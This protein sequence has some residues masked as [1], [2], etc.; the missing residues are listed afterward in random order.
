MTCPGDVPAAHPATQGPAG[1][2]G[3][4]AEGRYRHPDTSNF[5]DKATSD[6]RFLGLH[7]TA[8]DSASLGGAPAASYVS[9]THG[10]TLFQDVRTVPNNALQFVPL[11]GRPLWALHLVCTSLPTGG[12]IVSDIGLRNI[13]GEALDLFVRPNNGASFHDVVQPAFTALFGS[14]LVTLHGAFANGDTLNVTI[15][16]YETA[17]DCHFITQGTI[18]RST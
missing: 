10:G 14:G 1:P 8:D 9:G 16:S 4:T 12:P 6:A 18:A 15:G 13:S 11:P 7:A 2:R 5:Y 3:L 17:T